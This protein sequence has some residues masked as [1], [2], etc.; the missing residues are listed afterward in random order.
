MATACAIGAAALSMALRPAGIVRSQSGGLAWLNDSTWHWNDWSDVQLLGNGTFV[1]Q[2]CAGDCRWWVEDGKGGKGDK[3]KILW[4]GDGLHTM[5]L[6]GHTLRGK[7]N[8]DGDRCSA[9]LVSRAVF[10]HGQRLPSSVEQ[11]LPY[12]FRGESDL[13]LSLLAGILGLAV[14]LFGLLFAATHASET[15]AAA[16]RSRQVLSLAAKMSDQE[17]DALSAKLSRRRG[18]MAEAAASPQP[19]NDEEPIGHPVLFCSPRQLAQLLSWLLPGC[20]YYSSTA[21]DVCLV[22][23]GALTLAAAGP[24]VAHPPGFPLWTFLG[25]VTAQMP[26]RVIRNVNLLSAASATALCHL[27]WRL[28]RRWVLRASVIGASGSRHRLGPLVELGPL[29][30]SLLAGLSFPVWGFATFAEVYHVTSACLVASILVTCQ[31]RDDAGGGD[32]RQIALAGLLFGL[33]GCSHH[34]TAALALPAMIYLAASRPANG[35]DGSVDV[36]DDQQLTA[37]SAGSDESSIVSP[38]LIGASPAT[39]ENV[40][41]ARW[42]FYAFLGRGVPRQEGSCDVDMRSP[43]WMAVRNVSIAALG[44]LL[45]G[46]VFYSSI[47][48][49]GRRHPLWNWGGVDDAQKWWWHVSGK[50]YQV[51]LGQFRME[52]LLLET[53]RTTSAS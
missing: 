40:N 16:A 53:K 13:R 42:R 32:D 19:A 26:G 2:N 52:H 3:L 47:Y 49:I 11:L 1:A 8:S 9:T 22:D 39:H 6:H 48:V 23:A 45:P 46:L 35:V 38:H 4:G 20:I 41:E 50:Q 28:S 31:W 17:F 30:G 10:V 7:R 36:S 12:F 25:W 51:N 33:A 24:G 34:I 15:D 18:A 27:L 5:R 37:S 21:P 14:T 44:A 43:W 29:A